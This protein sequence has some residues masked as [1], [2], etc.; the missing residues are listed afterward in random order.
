M[1]ITTT[2]A[3]AMLAVSDGE[4]RRLLREHLLEGRRMGSMWLV[5]VGSVHRRRRLDLARGRAWVPRVAFAAMLVLAG[6]SDAGLSESELSRLRRSLRDSDALDVVRRARDLITT[7][8]WR[9]P[10]SRLDRLAAAPGVFV[11]GESAI[12]L[13]SDELESSE[14][15]SRVTHLAV[16]SVDLERVRGVS[17]ARHA[18]ESANVVM[19]I[20]RTDLAD[21][22][23]DERVQ[24]VVAAVLLGSSEDTRVRSAATTHLSDCLAALTTRGRA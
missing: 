16:A 17:G 9:V 1:E 5:D 24:E 2:E 19:H 3:A 10:G 22:L 11:T 12:H 18:N 15:E 23:G 13:I 14:P 6:R 20:L 21:R 8:R 7:E 4:V